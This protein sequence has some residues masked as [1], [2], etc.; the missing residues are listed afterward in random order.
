MRYARRRDA[1]EKGLPGLARFFRAA[2]ESALFHA[3]NHFTNVNR[4]GTARENLRSLE[5]AKHAAARL[6]NDALPYAQERGFGLARYSFFDMDQAEK[7]Q[8]DRYPGFDT[9][10]AA[11]ADIPG[12]RYFVCSSCGFTAIG[13][14][15]P[16]NCPL[17][18]A[19]ADKIREIA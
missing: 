17:C 10:L 1:D 9:L 19:P 15:H 6:Y 4:L 12:Q 16:A 18:G 7:T 2:A 14:E 5:S 3:R 11:G 13:G 8:L